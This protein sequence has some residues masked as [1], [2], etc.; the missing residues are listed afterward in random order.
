M[1]KAL[2]TQV[3]MLTCF[4]SASWEGKELKEIECFTMYIYKQCNILQKK[5]RKKKENVLLQALK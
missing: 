5:K 2:K 3:P 1:Q 4:P